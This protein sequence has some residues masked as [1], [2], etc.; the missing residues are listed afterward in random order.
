MAPRLLF[1]RAGDTLTGYPNS[2]RRLYFP[3]IFAVIIESAQY[4]ILV[5]ERAITRCFFDYQ[6]MGFKP[7]KITYG[8]VE[9]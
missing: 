1:I 4:S 5:E 7:K 6:D 2:L 9:F 3:I 8:K